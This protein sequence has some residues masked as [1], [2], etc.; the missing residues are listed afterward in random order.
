M[1]MSEPDWLVACRRACERVRGA[2]AGL[3]EGG[4][5]L[6]RGEGGDTTLALDRAAEDAVLAE[7]DA[8]GLPLT[9]VAEERGELALNGG[10]PPLVVL[11]PVDGSLNAKR[12]LPFHAVS[13]AVAD[14][15]SMGDVSFGYVTDL[16]AGDEWW[17]QRGGGAFHDGERLPPLA[18]GPL[19]VLGVETAR[20]RLMAAAAP[21]LARLEARRLRVLG[22]VALSLCLVADGRLDAML[23]LREV[24][25]VDVAAGQ[26]IVH[27]AGGAVAFPEGGPDPGLE[28]AAR[29]RV[30]AARGDELLAQLAG[31]G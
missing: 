5:E 4:R 18:A 27:E 16:P 15:T 3:V 9:L 8:L 23:S 22:S 10:G 7:L 14:G 11:D 24:R 28:L 1:S 31:A 6:G 2:L 26:L 20:P 19:E 25:S 30:L 29:Y 12:G 21:G 17:A 13:I